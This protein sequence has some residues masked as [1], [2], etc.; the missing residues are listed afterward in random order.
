MLFKLKI[1]VL[2]LSKLVAMATTCNFGS[3]SAQCQNNFSSNITEQG[4]FFHFFLIFTIFFP[5]PGCPLSSPRVF[6]FITFF[7]CCSSFVIFLSYIFA[8]NIIIHTII[9]RIRHHVHKNNISHS[10][11]Y[12]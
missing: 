9:T 11:L 4:I 5:L 10:H 7:G 2:F 8:H 1:Y 12:T 6:V 3:L